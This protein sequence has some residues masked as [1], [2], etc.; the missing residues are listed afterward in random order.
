[1]IVND[2]LKV[3]LNTAEFFMGRT[4]SHSYWMTSDV[5]FRKVKTMRLI[6]GNALLDS[7]LKGITFKRKSRIKLD[8]LGP[9]Y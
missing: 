9:G 1:M 4:N 6:T 2:T 5:R 3:P 7:A 8:L